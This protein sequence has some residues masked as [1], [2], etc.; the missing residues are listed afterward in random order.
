MFHILTFTVIKDVNLLK[1][2]GIA[3]STANMMEFL[4]SGIVNLLIAFFIQRGVGIE[5]AFISILV[6]GILSF[7]SALFIDY[8]DIEI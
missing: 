5:K 3:T 6:F 2:S 1:N 4:G 8:K 7:I